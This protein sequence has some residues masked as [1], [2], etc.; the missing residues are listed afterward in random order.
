MTVESKKLESAL[1]GELMLE[2][3]MLTEL[4]FRM[5]AEMFEDPFHQH[6]FTAILRL[7]QEGRTADLITLATDRERLG[8]ADNCLLELSDIARNACSTYHFPTHAA[9][10][11]AQYK[12]RCLM[13]LGLE[14]QSPAGRAADEM[15]AL[16]EERL[17]SLT[18]QTTVKAPTAIAEDTDRLQTRLSEATQT[19]QRITGIETGFKRLD[20]LTL[21]LH[22][23][24]LTILAAR[25]AQGKSAMALTIARNVALQGTPVALFSLEMGRSQLMDRLLMQQ[26]GLAGDKVRGGVLTADEMQTATAALTAL[27]SLPIYIDDSAGLSTLELRQKVRKLVYKQGVRLIIVDYLQLM[28]TPVSSHATRENEV[29]KISRALKTLAQELRVP[30]IALSQLNREMERGAEVREPRLSDL[31]ESGAIEQDADMVL[32]LHDSPHKHFPEERMLILAKQRS[33]ATGNILLSFKKEI[34]KFE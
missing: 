4:P 31:R 19:G 29:S 25:P 30:I 34:A 22:P 24:E 21:G 5:T 13:K 33:G 3:T 14:L 23:S 27:R 28:T 16:A 12:S 32:M 20:N 9:V 11:F 7:T 2:P 6:L 26:S 1:L 15:I 8:L 18:E 10:L 17:Y